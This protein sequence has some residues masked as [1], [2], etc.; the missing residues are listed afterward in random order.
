MAE[1][2]RTMG[3]KVALES[4][5]GDVREAPACIKKRE[6][7]IGSGAVLS[8]LVNDKE[9]PSRPSVNNM[10]MTNPGFE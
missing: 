3:D 1:E 2:E 4:T 8:V 10:D 6:Q 9:S 5:I 7:E